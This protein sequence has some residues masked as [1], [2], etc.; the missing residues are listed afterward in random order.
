MNRSIRTNIFVHLSIIALMVAVTSI[1]TAQSLLKKIKNKAAQT[2]TGEILNQTDKA[3]SKGMDKAIN[4]GTA[5]QD[6]SKGDATK[7]GNSADDQQGTQRVKA[8]SKYDF[9]PGDSVLY[10]NDFSNEAIGEL[11]TAWNSN[12]SSVVVKLDGIDGQW[13]RM[14][15]RTVCLTDNKKLLGPDFTVEFDL[16][17]QFDFKGWLPPSLRFG[18]LASGKG[19]PTDNRLLSD[20]KGEKSFYMELSP[21]ADGA[22]LMLESYKEFTRYFYS[23]PH[24]S[25]LAEE[26]YGKVLHVSMQG[27]KERLR[28]WVEGEKIY[29][30]PKAIPLDGIFNQLFFQLSSSPYQEDQIGVYLTNIKVGKGLPD[31]RHKLIEEGKFSTTG[32]LFDTGSATIKEISSGVLKSIA[33]VLNQNKDV[34]VRIV[35]HTDAVGDEKANQLLSER[36]ATAV[37]ENLQSVYGIMADRLEAVGKGESEPI[38]ENKT[39]EGMTQNR[40]VEFVRL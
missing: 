25:T 38:G 19:D 7:D 22:N 31:T 39:K 29:D 36:R 35:G 12:G 16:F 2:V 13:L 14:A 24:R 9:V 6:V 34:K 28:I 20:P 30:V 23:P 1:A 33:E 5:E 37:K 17:L 4:S 11:P 32:I 10:V 3:V 8:F 40:R 15:Q 27:Q 26:W 18:L 21:M